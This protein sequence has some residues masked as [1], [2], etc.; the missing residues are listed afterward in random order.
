MNQ[1][2]LLAELF[3][4]G[5]KVWADGDQLRVRA[6]KG[7]LTPQLRDSLAVHKREILSLACSSTIAIRDPHVPLVT[8]SRKAKLPLSFG[9]ERLWYL[10]QLHPD[11]PIYNLPKALHLTGP[12]SVSALGQSLRE[13]VQRHETFRTTFPAVEG[14]PVQ[15]ISSDIPVKLAV[16]DLRGLHGTARQAEVQ[17]L[18]SEE[19][20]Q[21]FN[22]AQGPLFRVKL[23]QLGEEEHLFF[24]TAHHIVFDGWSFD[25]FCRELAA[26]YE[27]FS[28]G[29]PS[30]LPELPIQYADFA[31]WE[32]QW[33][34][35]EVLESQLAYWRQQLGGRVAALALPIDRPRPQGHSSQGALQS[36]VLPQNLT[37]ALK[38]LSRREERTLFM[39]LLAAFQTLLYSYTG[40]ED[41]VVCSP[42]AG[43]H[44]SETRDLIGYFTRLLPMRTDLSGNP[45]FR[46]ILG[47]VRRVVSDAYAHQDLPLQMLAE[48]PNLVRTPLSRGMFLLQTPSQLPEPPGLIAT[49]LDVYNGAADFDLSLSM[50]ETGTTLKG[51]LE[52]KI[53]LFEARTIREMT[54][55]FQTLLEEI[56]A[57]P[58]QRVSQLPL[59]SEAQRD[60]LLAVQNDARTDAAL[61]HSLSLVSDWNVERQGPLAPGQVEPGANRPFMAPRD[62][63]ERRLTRIWEEVLSVQPIG[64]QDNFFDLGGHSLLAVRLCHRLAKATGQPVP[65]LRL[66]QAP[67]VAQLAAVLRQQE[68]SPPWT[69]L[70]PIHAAG[71]RTPLFIVP[72]AGMTIRAFAHCTRYLAPEQ[73]V[74][75]LQP[76]G[77]DG[78][79][80]HDCVE[81]MATYYLA[82]IRKLQPTGPY[83]LAGICFG[84]CVALEMAQQLHDRGEHVALLAILDAGPPD[85]RHLAVRLAWHWRQGSFVKTSCRHVA[86]RLKGLYNWLSPQRRPFQRV[87][88]A[89]EK[90][91]YAYQAKAY[92]GDI[93]LIQSQ[94]LAAVDYIRAEWAALTTGTFTYA[95]IPETTH[96]EILRQLSPLLIQQL[97]RHIPA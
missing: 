96:G 97:A 33:L 8:V 93:L 48:F 90:A 85:K 40:Q 15:I 28:T 13:I 37:E 62:E 39:T 60:Q 44:R 9:Q 35:H 5:V 47:R 63:L 56:V 50:E 83:M 46:E 95:V 22:L 81:A 34:Q 21:P 10:A 2:Q 88:D 36:L 42:L 71:T 69:T 17:R 54:R 61:P 66:F 38:A 19:S 24:L 18:A 64:V 72:P 45:G 53:D 59:Q 84:A 91:Y 57:N 26:L 30:P 49:H 86:L 94:Q 87:T 32:R 82:D 6:P 75:G 65:M 89:H 14:Q 58:E 79:A 77:F 67:T 25:V 52:Y 41:I 78:Q 29:K 4:R 92:A 74:Y 51:V 55:Q 23:L 12:L 80:P 73:P 27:A 70:V 31:H 16:V 11:N 3:H 76:L 43:R 1:H 7:A 20:Q 68:C